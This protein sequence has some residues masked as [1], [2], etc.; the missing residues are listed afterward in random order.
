MATEK[1]G[2]GAPPAPASE[3]LHLPGPSLLPVIVAAGI[4]FA[5]VGIVVNPAICILGVILTIGGIVKWIADT[6]SE[7]SELPL[8]HE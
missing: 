5:L 8:D 4:T 1:I 3:Q 6:R 2:A 7:I